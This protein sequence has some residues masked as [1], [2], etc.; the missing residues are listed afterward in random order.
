MVWA[1][2]VIGMS[3]EEYYVLL[4]LHDFGQAWELSSNGYY[5]PFTYKSA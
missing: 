2:R 3:E 4:R 1:G 5:S